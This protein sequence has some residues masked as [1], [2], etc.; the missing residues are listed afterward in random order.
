MIFSFEESF[1]AS[2]VSV[3]YSIIGEENKIFASRK[4]FFRNRKSFFVNRIV[5]GIHGVNI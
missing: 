4:A 5:C 1:C 3:S 2:R